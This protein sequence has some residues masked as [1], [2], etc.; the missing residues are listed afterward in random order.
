ML[1]HFQATT[2][3]TDRFVIF[4]RAYFR[5]H[6]CL[7]C[8]QVHRLYIHYYVGRLIRDPATENNVEIVIC[9]IICYIAK[10]EGKQYT[11]RMIPPFVTPECNIT[12]EH[13]VRMFKA[14]PDGKIDFSHANGFLGTANAKTIL[15]HYQMVS[16][17]T[18]LAVSFLAA[19]L[20]LSSPFLVQPG[21]PPYER[22]FT[23]L[24]LLMKAMYQAHLQRSGKP[25]DPPPALLYLHPVYVCK[26]SRSTGAGKNLLN[27]VSGIRFYF[28]SS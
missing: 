12:L 17:Y 20:A 22:L 5:K 9:V 27:L 15:R 21:Q 28:D 26:K 8:S 23:L 19:Y 1:E 18:E 2:Y 3:N 11:K 10:G 6:P 24:L 7:L 13:A 16:A 14:M 4:L 25:C